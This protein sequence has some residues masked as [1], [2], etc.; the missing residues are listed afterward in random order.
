MITAEQVQKLRAV[1]APESSVLSLYLHV[2][3][4]AAALRSLPERADEMVARAT[5]DDGGE[6]LAVPRPPAGVA[7][8]LRFALPPP[9]SRNPGCQP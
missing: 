3:T 5:L 8:Q 2:P 4:V 9:A 1:R 7:A 6:V